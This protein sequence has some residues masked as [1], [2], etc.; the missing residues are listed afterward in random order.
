MKLEGQ[1]PA[2]D[3]A[4]ATL[5]VSGSPVVIE[6]KARSGYLH[7]TQWGDVSADAVTD[8]PVRAWLGPLDHAAAVDRSLVRVA[9]TATGIVAVPSG[10]PWPEA[11]S[12]GG[13]EDA[14][15]VTL[16]A[17]AALLVQRLVLGLETETRTVE[18]RSSR[19]TTS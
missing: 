4:V 1:G 19:W 18:W 16:G 5:A 6:P 7:Q 15:P 12:T 9:L 2:I 13:A 11:R 10:V 8:A 14:D 3:V 17:F